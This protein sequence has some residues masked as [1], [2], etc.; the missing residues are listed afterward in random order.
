ML[1]DH[2]LPGGLREGLPRRGRAA[3]RVFAGNAFKRLLA[4]S[5]LQFLPHLPADPQKQQPAGEE[6]A[7]DLQKL[8]GGGGKADA[9][10][11]GGDD[12]KQD[13]LGALIL[14]QA[15]RG[16]AD[17]DGVVAGQNQVDHDDLEQRRH[18]FGGEKGIDNFCHTAPLISEGRR[19]FQSCSGAIALAYRHLLPE[20]RDV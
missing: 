8:G 20:F 10:D 2:D 19:S 4:M 9:Q 15:G 1:R 14:G 13:R 7:D 6:Q 16:K 11:G 3:M 5:M 12:A 17:D 18:R